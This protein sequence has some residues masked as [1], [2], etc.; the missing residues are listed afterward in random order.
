MDDRLFATFLRELC[1][2]SSFGKKLYDL[3]GSWEKAKGLANSTQ[4]DPV[5]KLRHEVGYLRFSGH[6]K[7][8]HQKYI[9]GDPG[10]GV[11]FH[12]S[13][14]YRYCG[15]VSSYSSQEEFYKRPFGPVYSELKQVPGGDRTFAFDLIESVYRYVVPHPSLRPSGLCIE[16]STG[17]LLGFNLLYFGA[18]EFGKQDWTR[19]IN[20]AW[21]TSNDVWKTVESQGK[22][23][24]ARAE[25]QARQKNESTEFV[26]FELEDAVCNYQKAH[27]FGG[28]PDL[29][30]NG[31]ISIEDFAKVYLSAFGR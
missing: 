26:V 24:V 3:I 18:R 8:F 14:L 1:G 29:F 22:R 15:L 2:N 10:R 13:S 20:D 31:E 9:I 12:E 6:R 19:K 17:P 5:V 16:G 11:E 7:I 28:S 30:L 25:E 27:K 4:S 23:L 21:G